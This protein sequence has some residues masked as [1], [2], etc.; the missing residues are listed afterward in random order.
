MADMTNNL[1]AIPFSYLISGGAIIASGTASATLTFASDSLFELHFFYGS[2]SLD[3][4]TDTRPN[5]FSVQITDQATGRQFSNARIPQRL[6]V[7]RAEEGF[8]ERRPIV[9]PR[10][11]VFVF[12]FLNLSSASTNTPTIVLKGYKLFARL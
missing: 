4:A 6:M 10:N 8:P 1:E 5:N 12:D 9:F 11:T 2:S 7:E 3:A